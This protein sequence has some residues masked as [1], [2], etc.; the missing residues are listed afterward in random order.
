MGRPPPPPTFP[1]PISSA[2]GPTIHRND[3]I[4]RY[5]ARA[6]NQYCSAPGTA[7]SAPPGRARCRGDHNAA[8][9]YGLAYAAEIPYQIQRGQRRL[10]FRTDR[11]RGSGQGDLVDV[12]APA[13]SDWAHLTPTG[14]TSEDQGRVA[15]KAFIGTQPESLHDTR[16]QAFSQP[17]RLLDEA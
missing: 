13:V 16:S 1:S 15:G 3:A 12:V 10:S 8:T 6:C 14:H 7:D 2:A 11:M 17:T 4:D 9:E 5:L